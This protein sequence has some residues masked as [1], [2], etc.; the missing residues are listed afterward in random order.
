MH[1]GALN[2]QHARLL[3]FGINGS[4]LIKLSNADDIA[5]LKEAVEL[6][7]KLAQGRDGRGQIPDDFWPTYS[8]FANTRGGI[9]LLGIREKPDQFEL[10]GVA[11]A[12]K[13]RS[14]LFNTLNNRQKASVNLLG[15][16][17]IY[18]FVLSE[19]TIIAV[20]V[21]AAN[22]RQKPVFINGNPMTGT[23]RRL[24]D[25]DRLCDGETVRR[26]LA[27][28]VDDTRDGRVLDK[29]GLDDVNIESLRTYRQM[30]RDAQPDHPYLDK[31]D[32]G[33]LR[34]IGA[35]R[36]DRET[37][38]N[39]LTVA[40]LLMFGRSE[41]IVEEFPEYFLD[42]QERDTSKAEMR[43][44]DRVTIDGTWS[45]NV[46]DFFRIV[47]RKLI[48]NLK[49]PFVLRG[50]QRKAETPIHVAL[51]EALVNALVHADYGGRA[52]IYIVKR[53][54]MF[55]FRNPGLMRIPIS[56]AIEGGESD[57]RNRLLQSM[58]LLVGAGE[59][60]GS[61]V[62]K[63]YKGWKEQHWRIPALYQRE[64]PSDQTLLELRMSDLLPAEIVQELRDTYGS[65]FDDLEPDQRLTLATAAT[66]G[67]VTHARMST[68]CGMHPVDL[69]RMLQGLVQEQFLR[70][71]GRG[72]GAA[73]HLLGAASLTPDTVF[74]PD[75]VVP[76]GGELEP[77]G[78]ELAPLGG[79]LKAARRRPPDTTVP[80]R[81]SHAR[82]GRVVEGLDRP[83]IDDLRTIDPILQQA[84]TAIAVK[85]VAYQRV[86]PA[87]M[88]QIISEICTKRYVTLKVLS[89]LVRREEKYLRDRI[90][91]PMIE[92]GEIVR[93]FPHAPNDP[94]QAY[95]YQPEENRG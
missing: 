4:T 59:R 5:L 33:F 17:D 26:M 8:A 28:Q 53:P 56:Q 62:P 75:P 52:S 44:T 30:L 47:Y 41:S 35:W 22:R 82:F 79:E 71:T 89:G 81:L 80:A 50:G 54:D 23:Y 14:D 16:D 88:S 10:A 90:I 65:R 9:I 34:S 21:P 83:I 12:D 51:R 74:G 63:I 92:R 69:T 29:F 31:D 95:L 6:E 77:L 60:A 45:G 38:R 70:Q 19:K 67:I 94:R 32:V 40:G 64:E 3:C 2:L 57:G 91:N 61:G 36:R 24:N 18:S 58:F 7:C 55:G 20:N 73:Y 15:E 66:E 86:S 78:G 25:G 49:I 84:L 1:A 48:S 46:F 72:R 68:V 87:T 42:Y 13:L 43:W 37:S 27:E 76:L 85:C 93:A 11:N 39:G